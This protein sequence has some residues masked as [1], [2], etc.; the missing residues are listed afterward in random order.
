M[1]KRFK[2]ICS[3]VSHT[4][5]VSPL[6][7]CWVVLFSV[8]FVFC[9]WQLIYFWILFPF[10]KK[11]TVSS[12]TSRKFLGN[13]WV[14]FPICSF[15]FSGIATSESQQHSLARTNYFLV[16]RKWCMKSCDSHKIEQSCVGQQFSDMNTGTEQILAGQCWG[17]H[18][19]NK[20]LRFIPDA[21]NF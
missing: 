18:S 5:I 9:M 14:H 21:R 13:L 8:C 10:E 17:L 11:V 2:I 16:S 1:W 19:R 7:C 12:K 6:F 3:F 20:A 4:K 15:Q